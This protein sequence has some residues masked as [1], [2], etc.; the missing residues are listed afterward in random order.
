MVYFHYFRIVICRE[1]IGLRAVISCQRTTA[2]Q[3]PNTDEKAVPQHP[4]LEC[5]FL[6]NKDEQKFDSELDR[7][8]CSTPIQLK[9]LPGTTTNHF[10]R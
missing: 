8:I 5:Q 4:D 6:I 9:K 10:L 2:V 1:K 7:T 3:G